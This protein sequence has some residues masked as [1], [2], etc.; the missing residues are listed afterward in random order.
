[1]ISTIPLSGDT[2]KLRARAEVAL[3]CPGCSKSGGLRR[4]GGGANGSRFIC[5]SYRYDPM[6]GNECRFVF[7]VNDSQLVRFK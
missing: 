7:R 3:T 2:I 6:H 1:M 4:V 5:E